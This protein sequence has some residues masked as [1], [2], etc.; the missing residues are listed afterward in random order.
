MIG[1]RPMVALLVVWKETKKKLGMFLVALPMVA[2][3]K[4]LPKKWV[5]S[6]KV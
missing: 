4:D 3:E 1:N 2:P 5:A 6:E